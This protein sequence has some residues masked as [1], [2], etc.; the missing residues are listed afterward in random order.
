MHGSIEK[1]LAATGAHALDAVFIGK[2]PVSTGRL[3][4]CLS[5][6][7][8]TRLTMLCFTLSLYCDYAR[9]LT[10]ARIGV[11]GI[12]AIEV[13]RSPVPVSHLPQRL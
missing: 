7:A 11:A 6:L 2:G 5:T 3:C 8:D 9:G 1:C 10:P 13:M 12:V 4:C